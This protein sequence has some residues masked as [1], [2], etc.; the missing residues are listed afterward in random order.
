MTR[1]ELAA[2]ADDCD[3]AIAEAL[4]A[5]ADEWHGLDDCPSVDD[6]AALARLIGE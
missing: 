5:L 1:E 4:A 2:L 6:C 3:R